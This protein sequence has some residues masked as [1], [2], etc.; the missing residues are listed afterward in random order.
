MKLYDIPMEAA[1]IEA[2]LADS[3]GEL[4]PEL[5]ARIN[6]FMSGGK[7]K[8][9]TAAMVVRSLESDA[10]VCEGEA[11][12][13]KARAD[14][15]TNSVARLKGLMLAAVDGGFGGKVKT[16]KFT[17]WGQTSAPG[18]EIIL[19][20]PLTV[21]DLPAKFLRITPPEINK[22]ELL[23]AFE[24]GDFIPNPERMEIV[25]RPGT[26]FLRIK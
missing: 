15:L 21:A 18:H 24:A 12:R 22:K 14:S 13:L 10:E 2:I 19:K 26:R 3:G 23:A 1:E 17:V 7:D 16:A 25:P 6:D 4:T 8:I 20:D 9:E 5:E 11:K